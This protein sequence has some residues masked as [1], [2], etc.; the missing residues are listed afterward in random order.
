MLHLQRRCSVI[1]AKR[2]SSSNFGLVFFL[3]EATVESLQSHHIHTQFRWSSGPPV[4][5]LSWGTWVQSPGGV[6]LWNRD[7]PVSVV[8]LYWWPRCDWSLWSRLRWAS[9]WTITRPLY[10][11]CDYPTWSHTALL[12]QFHTHCRSSFQFHSR[13]SRLLRGSP[14]EK[15]AI[16]LHLYTVPLV[17][18]STRLLPVMRDPVSIPGGVLM[19]NWDSPF[20]VV[21]L[22]YINYE[23]EAQ[24][25]KYWDRY[26]SVHHV[27]FSGSSRI[28]ENIKP[29]I[30]HKT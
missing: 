28:R 7:S 29:K 24:P 1:P 5:F 11:Q 4:C 10:R 6:L 15:L 25:L 30:Q 27:K 14:V 3:F 12:F 2:L 13:H 21:S 9:S 26:R 23:S 20:S 19:W 18:W 8:S 17:Q 22:H 16:S